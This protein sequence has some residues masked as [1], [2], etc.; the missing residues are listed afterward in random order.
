MTT[1]TLVLPERDMKRLI[2]LAATGLDDLEYTVRQGDLLIELGFVEG[3]DTHGEYFKE[4]RTVVMLRRA[5]RAARDQVYPGV[6]VV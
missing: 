2:E 3:E 6:P 5:Y 4:L 1:K